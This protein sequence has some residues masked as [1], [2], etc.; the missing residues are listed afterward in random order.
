MTRYNEYGEARKQ[1]ATLETVIR[2]TTYQGEI[3]SIIKSGLDV[4]DVRE[5]KK[6]IKPSLRILEAVVTQRQLLADVT[7]LADRYPSQIEMPEVSEHLE[8]E[9]QKRL[10]TDMLEAFPGIF[11]E[12]GFA[13]GALMTLNFGSS[14]DR[15]QRFT[16]IP[17]GTNDTTSVRPINNEIDR[18]LPRANSYN[19]VIVA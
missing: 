6:P 11:E 16:R 3:P 18:P 17:D 2:Q 7:R 13:L 14:P 12:R 8:W 9:V 19:A 1:L 5:Y 4:F 10:N 15:I